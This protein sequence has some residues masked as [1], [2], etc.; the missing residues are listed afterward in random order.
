MIGVVTTMS[1]KTQRVIVQL[2][3]ID[4]PTE[5]WIK[6]PT[7]D[8]SLVPSTCSNA[9]LNK[10]KT[11]YDYLRWIKGVLFSEDKIQFKF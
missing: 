3:R 5:F 8:H 6:I 9:D 2:T 4:S 10:Q 1:R 7:N 11:H